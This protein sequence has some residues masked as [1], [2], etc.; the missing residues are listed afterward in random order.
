MEETQ[1]DRIEK[2]VG[3][4]LDHVKYTKLMRALSYGS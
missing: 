3:E 4:I 1:L 2:K